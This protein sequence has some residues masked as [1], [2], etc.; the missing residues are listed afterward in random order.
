MSQTMTRHT[1]MRENRIFAGTTG[2]SQNNRRLR[3]VPAFRDEA[4]GRIER[5]CFEDGRP[6]P[7]HLLCGVPDEWVTER[8]AEGHVIAVRDSVI[9]G[10][11]REGVFYTREEAAALG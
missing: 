11:L 6:A 2:V 5:A 9:S 8:D 10:F 3:L 1:L 7:V 4:S